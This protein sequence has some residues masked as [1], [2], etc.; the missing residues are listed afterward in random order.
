M[1]HKRSVF[2]SQVWSSNPHIP[3]YIRV[4]LP[5]VVNGLV[6]Q[7][8]FHMDPILQTVT[9]PYIH[10]IYL[11]VFQFLWRHR[12]YHNYHSSIFSSFHPLPKWVQN[13][14]LFIQNSSLNFTP[15]F[16]S[17]VCL[18]YPLSYTMLLR[19]DSEESLSWDFFIPISLHYG[20]SGYFPFC[21]YLLLNNQQILLFPHNFHSFC[22]LFSHFLPWTKQSK[23]KKKSFS[24][25]SSHK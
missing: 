6:L 18:S 20:G 16:L 15:I 21:F 23:F 12:K 10:L 2:V 19:A 24:I 25:G 3:H 17:I 4:S 11:Y 5:A 1:Q 8:T 22:F 7:T 13:I 14:F 9:T